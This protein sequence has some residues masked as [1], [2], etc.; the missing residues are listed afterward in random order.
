MAITRQEQSLYN[1]NPAFNLLDFPN[2]ILL[3]IFDT[4][5]PEEV[6]TA[7]RTCN[8]F[9]DVLTSN[10][11]WHSKFKR[12]FPTQYLA[13]SEET[14]N[15]TTSILALAF[16]QTYLK[17][18]R[19]LY[20]NMRLLFSKINEGRIP[21]VIEK[22]KADSS[23]NVIQENSLSPI[24]I[25]LKHDLLFVLETLLR[26]GAKK[27]DKLLYDAAQNGQTKAVKILLP[28]GVNVNFNCNDDS[29]SLYIASQNGHHKIVE[30]LAKHGAWLEAAFRE[31][32]PLYIACQNG[33]YDAAKILL[34][35]GANV[36]ASCD[37][38]STSL[39]IAAQQGR[40]NIVEL[41]IQYK[42]NIECRY[43]GGFTPLY[44]AARNGCSDVVDYLLSK[45]A[46][47][48][49]HDG[50][51]STPVYVSAQNGHHLVV[52][53]LIENGANPDS[54]FMDG[55]SSAYIAC[56]NGNDKALQFLLSAGA[57]VNR[58]A[59]NGST[60]LYV[61]SQNGHIEC[62]RLLIQ[63]NVNLDT[64]FGSGYT[65]LYI[66]AQKGHLAIC[67]LLIKSG[68]NVNLQTNKKATALYVAAQKGYVEIV[69]LLLGNN[70]N[71]FLAFENGYWPI[72]IAAQENQ[73][74]VIKFL[75]LHVEKTHV[76]THMAKI[77]TKEEIK[78]LLLVKQYLEDKEDTEANINPNTLFA[79][80]F[81]SE[82]A[83]IQKLL[84][85]CLTDHDYNL[86]KFTET[87]SAANI[88]DDA[89]TELLKCY[90]HPNNTQ[91]VPRGGP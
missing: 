84:N 5:T 50:D 34:E 91:P 79:P 59:G 66:A 20:Y 26:L 1:T 54:L 49:A 38:G 6:P 4:L 78:A 52:K 39:Y 10:I 88:K 27:S 48:E 70:A 89:F 57:N 31:Y 86:Q 28:Y 40:K 90:L 19:P 68:A 2:E 64:T 25:A 11:F 13:L 9:H 17:L 16:I 72:H 83:L 15:K 37:S 62:V 51:G 56:Q 12:H 21:D 53:R 60:S 7:S 32:T 76:K 14:K 71:Y 43:R 81:N 30:I 82:G 47:Q 63:F 45:G 23:I 80:T 24:E 67:E 3:Y 35:L 61:A 46:N 41:L 55:Y 85:Q 36:E 18:Y 77:N 22:V 75:L 87:F 73:L 69:K 65:P 29:T 58:I 33:H 74:E 42:A 44:V 8:L